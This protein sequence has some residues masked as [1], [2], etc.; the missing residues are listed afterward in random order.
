MDV[1][2][3]RQQ[4]R[5][6]RIAS[7]VNSIKNSENPDFEKLIMLCCMEWGISDR[8]AREYLKIAKFEVE[9]QLHA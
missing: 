9:N 3:L 1:I 8:T 2:K 4:E 5:I 7:M 6:K